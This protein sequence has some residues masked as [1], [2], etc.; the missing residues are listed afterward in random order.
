MSADR[1][2]SKFSFKTLNTSE[3]NWYFSRILKDNYYIEKN[4][5]YS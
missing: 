2:L 1:I 4:P 3:E 5:Q